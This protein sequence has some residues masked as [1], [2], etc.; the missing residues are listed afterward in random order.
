MILIADSGSTKTDWVLL[1]QNQ[2]MTF[3]QTAGFNP[4]YSDPS[5]LKQIISEHLE[6][7]I[8]SER[9]RKVFFYGS[10]CSTASKQ[11][12]VRSILLKFYP[13]A[14]IE[15]YHDLLGSARAVLKDEPGIA[16][17]L[18]TG[19]NS[20]LYD[21]HEVVEN[22]PSVGYF[23]GDEGSGTDFGKRL[24][25]HYLRDTLPLDIRNA[26]EEEFKLS[27]EKVMDAIYNQPLPNAFFGSFSPFIHE[28]STDPFI[29][30]IIESSFSDFFV[31]QVSR[32]TNYKNQKLSFVGSVA[33]HYRAILEGVAQKFAMTVAH[34]LPNP[35]EGLIEYYRA[36]VD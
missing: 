19:S 20:C 14:T 12:L 36:N 22:V 16:C 18:G 28:R 30:N 2:A 4:Y 32:Y 8:S 7:K 34:V 15:V 33:Y 25:A 26:L 9:I 17:I 24:M 31:H 29:K 6:K 35:V 11:E 5:V 21:G 13:G 10:G 3:V 1:N 27:F 23:Y